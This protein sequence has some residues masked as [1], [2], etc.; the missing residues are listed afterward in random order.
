MF[1][2]LPA[3]TSVRLLIVT[4]PGLALTG[5]LLG[6]Y[7]SGSMVHGMPVLKGY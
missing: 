1:E 2:I 4:M 6:V 5:I 7:L 3:D